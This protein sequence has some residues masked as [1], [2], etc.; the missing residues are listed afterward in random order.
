KP[1]NVAKLSHVCL[2]PGNL[3][4]LSKLTADA[5]HTRFG[6]TCGV[7]LAK[8]TDGYLVEA[9]N[10]RVAGAVT[11]P[12]PNAEEYPRAH[13]L[14]SAP[15][16]ANEAVVPAEAWA[17]AFKQIPLPRITKQTPILANLGVAMGKANTTLVTT[18][19]DSDKVQQ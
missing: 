3:A 17:K 11:G 19:L 16:G 6:A 2:L 9:T 4:A 14:E 5:Q 1:A 10:G 12:M 18:D 8:T 13:I 15:D 7:R